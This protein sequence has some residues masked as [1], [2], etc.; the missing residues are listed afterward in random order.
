M[1]T[2]KW[3]DENSA[4]LIIDIVQPLGTKCSKIKLSGYTVTACL[5]LKESS[6]NSTV[7][8]TFNSTKD[9]LIDYPWALFLGTTLQRATPRI[10]VLGFHGN[11][12]KRNAEGS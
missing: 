9:Q 3:E 7:R 6:S 2:T 5:Q 8:R 4:H 11:V 12:I 10:G 1:E